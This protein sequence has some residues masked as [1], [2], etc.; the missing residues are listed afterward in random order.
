MIREDDELFLKINQQILL[1]WKEDLEE[2]Q[3]KEKLWILESYL[4]ENDDELTK[5]IIIQLIEDNKLFCMNIKK[6][7][8]RYRKI[9]EEENLEEIIPNDF[10]RKIIK[11]FC[12]RENGNLLEDIHLSSIPYTNDSVQQYFNEIGNIPLLSDEEV[13]SLKEKMDKGDLS[14]KNKLIES[15]LRLVVSIAKKYIKSNIPLQDLIQEGNLGLITAVE[16]F[17]PKMEYKFSTHATGG[18]DKQL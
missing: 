13:I 18:F 7:V 15:N 10:L 11:C 6:I 17:D 14:A 2:D 12:I 8:D 16:K 4:P 3:I 1:E 5:K 9:I